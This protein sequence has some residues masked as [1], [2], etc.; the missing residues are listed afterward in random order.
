MNAFFWSRK[1]PSKELVLQVDALLSQLFPEEKLDAALAFKLLLDRENVHDFRST[2]MSTDMSIDSLDEALAS[3]VIAEYGDD[4][5]EE[6]DGVI[7]SVIGAVP[8]EENSDQSG[9]DDLRPVEVTIPEE[10]ERHWTKIRSIFQAWDDEP[11]EREKKMNRMAEL[12]L[13]YRVLEKMLIPK[14]LTAMTFET[15]KYVSHVF[16]AMTV[17][18]F[19][20]F[21]EYVGDRPEIMKWL[22]EGYK[23][24]NTA[25]ICGSMLRD[26]FE[27]ESLT[28]L[29]LNELHHEFEVLFK[30]TKT[31]TNFDISADAFRNIT[32]LLMGHKAV[33]VTCLDVSFDRIFG[34]LNSLLS[35]CNYVTKRQALQLLAELLLDPVNFS[36]M[37][38]YIASRENLKLV[39]M[40]LRETSQALRMD[41][42]HVFKIFVANPNK[43]PEVAQLLVRNRD[44]LLTF[45]REFGKTESNREFQQE[46]SL[47]VF[48]LQRLVEPLPQPLK[49]AASLPSM[50]SSSTSST[51]SSLSSFTS[52]GTS[53]PSPS[54]LSMRKSISEIKPK[55]RVRE[56]NT[57][58]ATADTMVTT[59]WGK[60][61]T[62]LATHPIRTKAIT[63]AFV[64]MFGEILGH[65]LK[66]KTLKGLS[67]RQV[68]AFFAFG[69]FV[70][71]PVLHYWYMFLENQTF[72]KQKLTPNKKLLLDRLVYTPP[73]TALTLFSLGV[74]RGSSPKASM[75][76]VKRIYW[77]ALLMNWRVW[78]VTQWLSFH[79]VPPQFR[80]LWGNCVAL[81]WNAYLSLAQN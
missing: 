63:S 5:R 54:S 80:V 35:A 78:T 46:K 51:T 8:E 67:P 38:R 26:C 73:F 76:T 10:L 55:R 17:H 29:F 47:L 66:H 20:G 53:P 81:W 23:N 39:M 71:G 3:C 50:Q 27:H 75:E 25:L 18:D 62:A 15:R 6:T 74:M 58:R 77:G 2:V 59:A 13:R 28:L 72:T 79:Y 61:Q 32:K 11:T 60:Y 1:K 7:G 70:T 37:Q 16:R 65:V 12:L 36:V 31:N 21:I 40:L 30:V 4:G 64:G 68:L 43:S 56:R 48:T 41:A 42:F 33:T 57:V 14:V 19:Q 9:E 34:L 45:I 44:K 69:G 24:N 49:T 22:V 52:T